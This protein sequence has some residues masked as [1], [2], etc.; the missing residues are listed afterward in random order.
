MGASVVPSTVIRF[1]SLIP[2]YYL[3]FDGIRLYNDV[4]K[5]EVFRMLPHGAMFLEGL[6]IAGQAVWELW[7]ISQDPV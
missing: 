2:L 4:T 5:L 7:K 6:Q 1:A 3:A